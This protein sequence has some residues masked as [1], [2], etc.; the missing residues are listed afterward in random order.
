MVTAA[1]V[2]PSSLGRS[3]GLFFFLYFPLLSSQFL[4]RI[5]KPSRSSEPLSLKGDVRNYPHAI[6]KTTLFAPTMTC[7]RDAEKSNSKI[8]RNR[9][10]CSRAALPA[11]HQSE[12]DAHSLMAVCQ[13]GRLS[14]ITAL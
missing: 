8:E 5:L 1:D 13:W 12:H 11:T 9:I 10:D 14:T 3:L 7:T 2:L 4:G 6:G